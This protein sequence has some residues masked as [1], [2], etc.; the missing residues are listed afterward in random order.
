M[1]GSFQPSEKMAQK[2]FRPMLTYSDEAHHAVAPVL[3]RVIQYFVPD[4]L[5]GLTATDKRPDKKELEEV[6]GNYKTSLSLIDAMKKGIVA[7]ANV[8]RIETNLDLSRIRFNGK[9]YVNADLEKNIRIT[10]RNELI[11]D[12]LEK[13]FT[14]ESM[15]H[16]QGVIFCVNQKHAAEMEKI[17]NSRG[18]S[19]RAYTRS[20]SNAEKVMKS[21]KNHEI[22][23]LCSCNMISEGWDYPEL[24]ILVMARPTLSKVL[25]MQQI[26][27][28]L[29]KTKTKKNVFIIDVV[30]EYGAMAKPCSMHAIFANSLYVPFGSILKTDYK[31]GEMIVVDG[32]R[33]TVEKIVEIDIETYEQK[34]G[35][36][37]NQ[38]QLARDFYISTGS[39]T[40]WIRKGRITPDVTFSFGSRKIYLFSPEH[41]QQIRQ[42]NNIAEHNDKTIY[43]DFFDFLNE[44]D[45]TLSYKMPFLLS[46]IKRI[47]EIGDARIE[48]I[49]T[50]YIDFYK[51]RLNQGLPA[52][53]ATCPYTNETLA[54]RTYIKQSMLTNPFEKFERK[55]FL[56]YSKD[57]GIISM[58]HALF[59]KLK[60]EDYENI[61]KQMKEDLE[62][63]Y[64][65]IGG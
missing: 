55:R 60:G 19:A 35:D 26:G 38:E 63:Y 7:E 30:D 10:S 23:F 51:D 14:E 28:G 16:L 2:T 56:Y 5:I 57:L 61:R 64:S 3:K 12:V 31:P 32:L 20:T 59:E 47:D 39:I 37:L 25:Y 15:Q 33:E 24:G 40:N 42:E 22:R 41:V 29:R 44:R 11:A 4:F 8:F 62:N 34:Y 18:I 21:F 48:D 43:K 6:F 53:R 17:L 9:D 27:R 45:Y 54:D 65:N 52:D 36:Y 49:L 46:L 58:N 13:Y 1:I 50:D